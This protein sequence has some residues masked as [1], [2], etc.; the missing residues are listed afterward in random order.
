MDLLEHSLQISKLKENAFQRLFRF[1]SAQTQDVNWTSGRLL[2]VL[3]KFNLRHVST[4]QCFYDCF[5][6][7]FC[8]RSHSEIYYFFPFLSLLRYETLVWGF[9]WGPFWVVSPYSWTDDESSSVNMQCK[10]I[11]CLL[12]HNRK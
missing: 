2:N 12:S 4:G 7:T 8:L 3:C 6:I 5:F 1:I 11:W 9:W 10:R